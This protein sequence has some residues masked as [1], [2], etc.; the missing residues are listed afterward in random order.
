MPFSSHLPLFRR[1]PYDQFFLPELQR[2]QQEQPDAPPEDGQQA[3]PL[4]P[5][6]CVSQVSVKDWLKAHCMLTQ[7]WQ[8]L[9]ETGNRVGTSEINVWRMAL[10]F[11]C[12]DRLCDSLGDAYPETFQTA[13][14]TGHTATLALSECPLGMLPGVHQNPPTISAAAWLA[15][16]CLHDDL[17][18]DLIN[19]GNR[20]AVSSGGSHEC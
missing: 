20:S 15:Q 19:I 1:A 18:K 12:R 11:S 16:V 8:Q 14:Q 10:L 3:L 7:N 9:V 17:F 4:R 5:A 6:T 13:Y 2:H